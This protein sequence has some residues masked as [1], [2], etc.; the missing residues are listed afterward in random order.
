MHDESF[1]SM[2][3]YIIWA[4]VLY[5]KFLFRKQIHNCSTVF[6][7][8]RFTQNLL[9]TLWNSL[10]SS[11]FSQFSSASGW[12]TDNH[13]IPSKC[14]LLHKNVR[15]REW[16]WTFWWVFK[17]HIMFK[18]GFH[19]VNFSNLTNFFCFSNNCDSTQPH[20]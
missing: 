2:L 5:W 20:H 18:G 3:P 7:L 12:L 19:Q 14:S 17:T 9:H 16:G 8:N 1:L 13:C 10:H 15:E 4:L 6:L 11:V